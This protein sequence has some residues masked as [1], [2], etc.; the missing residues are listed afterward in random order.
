M[1]VA[2]QF[3]GASGGW[4]ELGS[5]MPG[6]SAQLVLAFGGRHLLETPAPFD[7][8]RAA[9]PRARIVLAS[10]A[11]E[12]AGTVVTEDGIVATAL[13]FGKTRI[14]CAETEVLDPSRSHG[15]GTALAAQLAGPDLVSI[16]VVSDGQHVNGGE[17]TRG[18]NETL[19][20]GVVLTGGLAGDG[21]RF[22]RTVV[23]L[24]G[25]A[26]PGRVVAIGFYGKDLKVRYG[27]AGGWAPFGPLR[28]VTR[29][30]GNTLF[31]LDGRSALQLYKTYLGDQAS[32]L[33][34]SALR[35]PLSVTPI[36]AE[37]SVV[38][39]ILSIDEKSESMIFA[40]DI[41]VGASVRFMRASYDNLVDGAARAAEETRDPSAPELVLIVSCVGRRIV[42]GQR[43]E[44][45]TEVVRETV[46]A[47]PV[48]AGFYSY[49]ELAPS[50]GSGACRLHNQTMTITTLREL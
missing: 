13:S 1:R 49:G 20:A 24:D 18:F 46:G 8:L 3:F 11:G 16:F 36:G 10:T 31:E 43:T 28:T 42:L 17:L 44:E 50:A 15:A 19:A 33:P 21:T 4:K 34:G 30:E 23:G 38:R 47:S 35:F 9:Y 39:T 45:E 40:G 5:P 25:H 29:S 26:R 32:K 14:A 48:V 2:Q 7:H 41:P 22:E 37:T 27:S 6:E 12:I